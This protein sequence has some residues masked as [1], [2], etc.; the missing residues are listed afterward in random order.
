MQ[1]RNTFNCCFS[2]YHDF[3]DCRFCFRRIFCHKKTSASTA[4]EAIGELR[5]NARRAETRSRLRNDR[6][7]KA[8]CIEIEQLKRRRRKSQKEKKARE[9]KSCRK[10]TDELE[11]PASTRFVYVLS[12][13]RVAEWIIEQIKSNPAAQ[14]FTSTSNLSRLIIVFNYCLGN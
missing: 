3:R 1:R 2:N 14:C 13:L 10:P 5:N 4:D 6:V 9:R 7:R 12:S 11:L 8:I